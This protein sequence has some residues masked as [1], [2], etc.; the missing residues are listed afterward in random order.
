MAAHVDTTDF[1]YHA[2]TLTTTGSARGVDGPPGSESCEFYVETAG[3]VVYVQTGAQ[4]DGAT[5]LSVDGGKAPI[6]SWSE[7]DTTRISAPKA[8]SADGVTI[9][10]QADT[11]PTVIKYRFVPKAV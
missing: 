1:E 5:D 6:G 2:L 7:E 3:T 8:N 9:Y 10:F 11:N 4:V